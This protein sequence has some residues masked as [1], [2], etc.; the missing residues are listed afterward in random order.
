MPGLPCRAL[1]KRDG[2]HNAG[3]LGALCSRSV[4]CIVG[5]PIGGVFRELRRGVLLP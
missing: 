3:V 4:R 5:S 2:A 1:W